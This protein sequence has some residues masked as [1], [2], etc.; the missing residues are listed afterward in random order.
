MKVIEGS[1]EIARTPGE[2]FDDV[3]DASRLPEWQPAV[4]EAAAEA[5]AIRQ[6]G[7]HGYE[8]RQLPG[9]P[10]KVRWQVTECEPGRRWAIE[11]LDGPVRAHVS[12]SL[13][14]SDGAGTHVDYR[15]WFEGHGIGKILRLMATR[16][17]R[18]ELPQTLA[19]LKLRL[20]GARVGG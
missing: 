4:I 19:L 3:S 17:E 8:I 20:E 7:M 13:Q 11:G 10:K 18:S 15:V 6:V 14:P 1:T 2:V 16:G 5:P 9:G 12:I